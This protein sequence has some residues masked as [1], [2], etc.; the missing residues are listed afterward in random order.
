MLTEP[1][2]GRLRESDK[3]AI[4]A[5]G[6]GELPW[7]RLKQGTSGLREALPPTFRREAVASAAKRFSSLIGLQSDSSKHSSTSGE[8]P[9]SQ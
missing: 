2:S 8:H 5:M 3:Q 9:H 6:R 7:L 1:L 4:D